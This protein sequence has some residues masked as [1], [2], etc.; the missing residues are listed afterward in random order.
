MAARLLTVARAFVRR[1][2]DW[3]ELDKRMPDGEVAGSSPG[4]CQRQWMTKTPDEN[5]RKVVG[6]KKPGTETSACGATNLRIVAGQRYEFP[7]FCP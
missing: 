4:R 1:M 2:D 6:R 7:G 5:H 3:G